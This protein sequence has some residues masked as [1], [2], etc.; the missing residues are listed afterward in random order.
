MSIRQVFACHLAESILWQVNGLSVVEFLIARSRRT[1]KWNTSPWRQRLKFDDHV[2]KTALCLWAAVYNKCRH[3]AI[4]QK[5]A[6][7]PLVEVTLIFLYRLTPNASYSLLEYKWI[8]ARLPWH[9]HPSNIVPSINASLTL[10][11]KGRWVSE[12]TT[13]QVEITHV[14]SRVTSASEWAKLAFACSNAIFSWQ[15]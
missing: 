8:Y 10:I 15:I 14:L 9:R 1:Q 7:L 6:N 5:T 12:W 2:G 11:V 3:H 4:S 13:K